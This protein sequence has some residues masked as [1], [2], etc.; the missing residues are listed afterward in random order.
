MRSF[1]ESS[2]CQHWLVSEAEVN[3]SNQG[4]LVSSGLTR[5]ELLAVKVN[6]V[7]LLMEL[8]RQLRLRQTVTA[9]AITFLWR[10]YLRHDFTYHSPTLAFP[11]HGG[12]W[13]APACLRLAC[14]IEECPLPHLDVLAGAL[15]AIES[16]VHHGIDPSGPFLRLVAENEYRL[17]EALD[18]QLVVFKPYQDVLSFVAELGDSGKNMDSAKVGQLTQLSWNIVNDSYRCEACL[19]FPPHEVALA[20]VLLASEKLKLDSNTSEWWIGLDYNLEQVRK[21]ARYI[22]VNVYQKPQK[23]RQEIQVLAERLVTAWRDKT[24]ASTSKN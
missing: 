13:I 19:L 21:V 18:F 1:S 8:G 12:D 10:F 22:L 24:T 23:S 20:A 9:T 15:N 7:D 16:K 14:K 11:F 3:G 4:D 2:H 6:Y 5:D 17:F